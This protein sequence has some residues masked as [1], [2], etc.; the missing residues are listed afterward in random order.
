MNGRDGGFGLIELLVSVAITL[1]ITGAVFQLMNPARGAFRAQPEMADLQQRLRAATE[2]L[3]KELMMAGAGTYSGPVAGPLTSHFAPVLPYRAGGSNSDP[4]SNVFYRTDAITT[5]YVPSTASQTII[6]DDVPSSAS[7]LSV[8]TP[9]NCP[10]AK[11]DQICGLKEDMRVILF[12]ADGAWDRVTIA[13]VQDEVLSL[14]TAGELSTAYTRGTALSEASLHTYY[15]RTDTSGQTYQL[16]HYDGGSSDLPVVDDVI[17]LEF[18]YF[19]ERQP[20]AL[21]PD[22]PVS[23]AAG[24]WTTYGPKP[25]AV[26]QNGSFGW[27][28]GENCIFRVEDGV[29]VSRLPVLGAGVG[30]VA[31]DRAILT[32]GPWC[33]DASSPEPYDADLLRV[34][35]VRVT[36]RAQAAIESLRG[37]GELFLRPGTSIGG[38]RSV[39]DQEIRFDIAPR[40]LNLGR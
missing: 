36:L 18:Q 21:L 40:N 33:P 34:R 28:A 10:P 17:K 25:P 35:R 32:D 14:Q 37:Q 12:G 22:T 19:G 30:L 3:R 8:E 6:R 7:Q 13:Q 24:P 26:G 31:L 29:H 27:P 39:P 16:R 4:R 38:E 1:A 23:S 5:I 15:L 20:P 2:S 9:A 11:A